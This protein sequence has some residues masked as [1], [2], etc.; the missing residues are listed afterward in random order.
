MLFCL[1]W[2]VK[3]SQSPV[4]VAVHRPCVFP[5]AR[6]HRST[7][8]MCLCGT[9]LKPKVL[10]NGFW[11]AL[12]LSQLWLF[13][14]RLMPRE[15]SHCLSRAHTGER[16]NMQTHKRTCTH[17]HTHH[18]RTHVLKRNRSNSVYA[19]KMIDFSFG[20]IFVFPQRVIVSFD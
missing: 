19:T 16:S 1:L 5:S 7:L 12:T 2:K 20:F 10:N 13:I 3:L 6:N 18:G 9:S 17:T 11:L 8:T 14:V 15:V 4:F